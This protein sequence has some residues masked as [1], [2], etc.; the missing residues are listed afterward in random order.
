MSGG[1][2]D[3]R[4]P[5]AASAASRAHELDP[6]NAKPLYRLALAQR[7]MGDPQAALATLASAPQVPEVAL[8]RAEVQNDADVAAAQRDPGTQTALARLEQGFRR[9]EGA[10]GSTRSGAQAQRERERAWAGEDARERQQESRA[11]REARDAALRKQGDKQGDKQKGEA[12]D[13]DAPAPPTP[14]PSSFAALKAAKAAR[15]SYAG[16]T[17]AGAGMPGLVPVSTTRITSPP[18]AAAP[19]PP[20]AAPAGPPAAP[21]PAPPAPAP[22]TSTAQAPL[23]AHAAPPARKAE[24]PADPSSL[25]PGAGLSLLRTLGSLSPA[26]GF[27][28]LRHYP[29][30]IIPRLMDGLL[31]PDALGLLLRA[32]DAGRGTGCDDWIRQVLDG[33]KTNRRWRMTALM[34]PSSDREALARLTA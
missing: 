14:E 30:G 24:P 1:R 23:P 10:D 31:D 17:G 20:A 6:G 15:R 4:Y 22:T 29:A 33:L 28:Y 9:R 16:G 13:V 34:L 27:A 25:A 8:L 5:Q 7:G 32:L 2:A 12:M 18:P 11:E 3:S 21:S 26:D 19:A